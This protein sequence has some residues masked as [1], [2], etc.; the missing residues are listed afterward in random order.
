[1]EL[2]NQI[3]EELQQGSV[4]G[5]ENGVNKAIEEN[6]EA[7]KILHEGLMAGMKV[8]GEKF[9][10][11]EIFVPGVLVAARAM[12]AGMV[13]LKP[14][15]IESGVES[16]GKVVLGTV[17]GDLHDVGKN[18]VAMMLE[19]AGFEVFDLGTDVPAE[20]FVEKAKEVDADIVGLSALLTTTMNEMETVIKALEEAGIRDEVIVMVGGAPITSEFAEEI[21]ADYYAKDASEASTIAGNIKSKIA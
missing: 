16:A 18:L 4:E 17:K 20:K 14:K 11:D 12:N 13:I 21:S 2:L 1:M 19:G 6:I 5:V 3:S 9:K 10:N 15:L 8:I 7:E